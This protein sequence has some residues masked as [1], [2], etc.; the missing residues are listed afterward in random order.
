MH[1][2]EGPGFE[3]NNTHWVELLNDLPISIK[4]GPLHRSTFG[5]EA[6]HM[7]ISVNSVA[8]EVVKM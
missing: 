2:A 3:I 6:T 5:T 1:D 4:S 7:P 8:K